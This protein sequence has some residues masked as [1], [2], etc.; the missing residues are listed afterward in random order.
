MRH[1]TSFMLA[2]E[3]WT[4]SLVQMGSCIWREEDE[5]GKR[6]RWQQKVKVRERTFYMGWVGGHFFL[7]VNKTFHRQAA[8]LYIKIEVSL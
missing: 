8:S 6:S 1:V 5:R 4:S 7:C 2:K 3:A